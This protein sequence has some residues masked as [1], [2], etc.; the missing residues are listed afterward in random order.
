MRARHT[1]TDLFSTF[2]HFEDDRANHWVTD[3]ALRRHL[4]ACLKQP[5]AQTS[6]SFWALYWHQSW[7]THPERLAEGHLFAYLQESCYWAVQKTLPQIANPHY[8]LSDC[9]QMAIAEVPKILKACDPAI[10]ISLKAYAS[11]AF[12]NAVRDR[13]RQQREINLSSDWGLLVR[14]S[15]KQLREALHHAGLSGDTIENYLQAW[16]CF[17]TTCPAKTP[18]TRKLQS[19]DRAV[20]EA[21]AQCYNADRSASQPDVTPA[22]LE[23]WLIQCAKLARAYLYPVVA[24]LNVP[25]SGW[26]AGEI[27]DELPDSSGESLLSTLEAQE[28]AESREAQRTQ[29]QAV[30]LDAIAQLDAPLAQLIKLYYQQGL[31]QQQ[32]AQQLEL[33]Q[34][35]ISRKLAKAREALLIALARWSQDTLHTL[36][37]ST[38][39]KAV[40][41]YLEEWL[42]SHYQSSEPDS[43][44][45]EK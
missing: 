42:Q 18:S 1:L 9:F 19:P 37:T 35:T 4:L 15:R 26:D 5:N 43:A 45:E 7:Q 29:M 23:A 32:M 16:T 28:E 10:N 38:V 25:K 22:M 27:Q 36:P 6:E 39:V 12:G 3:S 41:I 33:P 13:L 34:Y 21:I 31:T 8:G 14:L 40:S 20:W 17:N 44:K 24:S 30:L 11:V 2:L